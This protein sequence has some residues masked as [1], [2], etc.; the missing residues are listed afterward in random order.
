[1][2][3]NYTPE[4]EDLKI[5]APFKMQ[6]LT[7]FPY[8][9][10]D[11]DA[12]TNYQLLCKVVEY[13][14]NVIAETNEVTEQ[15][16]SLYNA[17]VALQ[18]Y[19]NNEIGDFET[20]V[21]NRVDGLESYMN[22]YFNNLDVQ[23]EINNKL[24]AMAADG[25]LTVLIKNY[26]DPI[27][28]AYEEEIND[29]I[30]D[31]NNTII[32]LNNQI[33]SLSSGSPA[34]VYA[35]VAA[36]TAADPSHSSIY[37][38]S[39]DGKWYY[40]NNGTSSWTAG[41]TYQSTGIGVNE[42]DNENLVEIL[43]YSLNAEVLDIA[44]MSFTE[45]SYVNW[46]NGSI[47]SSNNF[48]LSEPIFLNAGDIIQFDA[49]GYL[50]A[51]AMLSMY[52]RNGVNTSLVRSID[53]SSHTYTYKAVVSNNYYISSHYLPTSI[54]IYRKNKNIVEKDNI[55]NEFIDN[56]I[57]NKLSDETFSDNTYITP[58]GNIYSA[59]NQ[60]LSD[61]IEVKNNALIRLECFNDRLQLAGNTTGLCLFDKNKTYITGYS[62]PTDLNYLEFTTTNNTKYIR[63]TV[64]E[65]MIP[66][67][68]LYYKEVSNL[69][70]RLENK[71]DNITYNASIL[72]MFTNITC[73]GDSLTY[74]QVYT[75]ASTS[76]QAYESYPEILAKYTGTDTTTLAHAGDSA[77]DCWD[78]YNSNITSKTNQLAIIYLGTNEGLTDTVDTDCVGDDYTSYANTNTGSYG[79]I[80][81]KFLDLNA[82]V[83]LVKCYAAGA[84]LTE[85][86]AAIESLASK[87]NVPFV[88]NTKFTADIYHY[89]P[90]LTGTNSTHYNDLGYTMFTRQ[91]IN[92]INNLDDSDKAKILPI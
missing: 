27:Y 6:V 53:S 57:I 25:T 16:L 52:K 67:Y 91:L 34:G 5:L 68:N 9:E 32:S 75:A 71:I 48:N 72:S 69:L 1:M 64:G 54:K 36:L 12:L 86:N 7:N 26:V 90:D 14:N 29:A 56:I 35:T 77:K 3:A 23:Q 47:A 85:T 66:G 61:Y 80:I 82:K 78:R 50:Q 88:S 92:N 55:N 42:V 19:V 24:D 4:K 13:L 18:N 22:N 62:Y 43:Q 46:D 79:K 87:F 51:V 41:G 65:Q 15:T 74:S 17:Y 60:K 30:E 33:T 31:Q 2:S 70:D 81:R 11:F 58:G 73:V 76:R 49:A 40:Y 83:I 45:N 21:N 20:T 59:N 89:Y 84:V 44:E 28:Q 39:E 38:V 10:A 63:L 37:V 8:I